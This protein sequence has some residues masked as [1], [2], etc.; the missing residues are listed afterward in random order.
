MRES[1][2]KEKLFLEMEGESYENDEAQYRINSKILPENFV[3]FF[4]FDGEEIE[5][6]SDNLRTKLREKIVEILQISP[7]EII[8][9]QIQRLRE[10]LITSESKNQA[11]KDNLQIKRKQQETKE[12]EIQAKNNAINKDQLQLQENAQKIKNLTR[13]LEKIIADSSAEL[14]ELTREKD[15]ADKDLL[16]FKQRL[17]DSIKSVAF[18]SN[19][20]LI[21]KLQSEIESIES[22]AQKGDI[23][24]LKRLI[25]S[26]QAIANEKIN[27]LKQETDTIQIF[28]NLFNDIINEMPSNLESKIAKDY[29]K[30]PL[31]YINVIRENIARAESSSVKQDIENIKKLK[32]RLNQIKAQIDE[33]NADEGAKIK[34][35]EIKDEITKCEEKEKEIKPQLE[36][37]KKALEQLN[38]EMLNLQK[39]IESLEQSIDTERIEHKLYLLDILCESM[40][41]YKDRL[42]SKLRDELHDKI[43]DKYKQ[44]IAEDNVKELEISEDF[45]IRLKDKYGESIIVESQSSGQKQILAISIFWALSELSNSKIPLIIDTPLSR[46]DE[47]NRS[48]IIKHYYGNGG[49]VIILPHSGEM[50]QR[51]YEFAKPNLAGLYKIDNSDDRSHATIKEVASI[52]EIL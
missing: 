40:N 18:V 41:I 24:A 16:S 3:E 17:I 14:K 9:K 48:K 34:Q 12:S 28:Q 38:F 46:I 13:K 47:T 39:E 4:F 44:I 52:D 23:E 42:I 20:N 33:L 10:E 11:Q 35:D 45:E 37:N 50:G 15:D 5:S 27:S 36:S 26:I 43:L 49:Q 1:Q 30:I 19:A 21:E 29:S 32:I 6:I 2:I 31:N 22:S 51:E 25:P 8:I 7:L